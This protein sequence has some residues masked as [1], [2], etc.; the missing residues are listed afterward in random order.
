[1]VADDPFV[2]VETEDEP[3]ARAALR[4]AC[5][6]AAASSAVDE[7]PFPDESSAGELSPDVS[8]VVVVV[9]VVDVVGEAVAPAPVSAGGLDPTPVSPAAGAVVVWPGAAG[10]VL[11]VWT[12][13]EEAL[14]EAGGVV[15]TPVSEAA[16][17]V[18]VWVGMEDGGAVLDRPEGPDGLAVEIA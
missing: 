15:P 5:S 13:D 6:W 4:A 10:A 14:L 11:D 1:V 18:V 2:E 16:G 9:G 3:P 7:S 12:D 8:G 17:V